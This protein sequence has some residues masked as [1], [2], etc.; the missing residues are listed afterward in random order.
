MITA[1]AFVRLIRSRVKELVIANTY[2][3]KQI[4]LAGTNT[5]KLCRIIKMQVLSGEQTISP[6]T[7][8]PQ[9]IQDLRGLF[10]TYRLYKKRNTQ[11]KNWIHSVLK[12]QLYV[13]RKSRMKIWEISPNPVLRFRIN[14]LMGRLE[15]EETDAGALK[16]RIP[17]FAESFMPQIDILTSMKG[18]G[19]PVSSACL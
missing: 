13:D 12:E 9:E 15:R 7:I 11:L 19:N 16:E 3:F 17:A 4:S 14:Q 10:F 5:D 18:E 6:V 2:E 8:L 1:F